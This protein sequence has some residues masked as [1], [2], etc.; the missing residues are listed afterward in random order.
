MRYGHRD[1]RDTQ[2]PKRARRQ[3]FDAALAG[4]LLLAFAVRDAIDIGLIQDLRRLSQFAV[5]NADYPPTDDE[6]VIG[7][8]DFESQI[9]A[10]SILGPG[11]ERI[12]VDEAM[13]LHDQLFPPGSSDSEAQ[14][15]CFGLSISGCHSALESYYKA[16]SQQP[17]HGNLI[18][19]NLRPWLDGRDPPEVIESRLYDALLDLDATRKIVVHHYGLVTD[20]YIRQVVGT[21][22][23]EGERR[24]LNIKVVLRL[25]SAAIRAADMI[26][27]YDI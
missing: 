7:P 3:E 26:E 1:P 13:T 11:F 14:D 8:I 27:R 20:A 23:L 24:P 15:I 4:S 18:N 10:S 2:S 17:G 12:S 16:V 9:D 5:D 19:E 25:A 21:P 6:P 22:L